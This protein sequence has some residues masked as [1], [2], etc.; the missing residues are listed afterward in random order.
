MRSC[1]F[2]EKKKKNLVLRLD[3]LLRVAETDKHNLVPSQHSSVKRKHSHKNM[4]YT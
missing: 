2:S 3:F 4:S 1:M